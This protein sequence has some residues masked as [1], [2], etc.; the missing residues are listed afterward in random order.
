M[1]K[2]ERIAFRILASLYP[3]RKPSEIRKIIDDALA[4]EECPDD[5]E[6]WMILAKDK[7]EEKPEKE[8][9]KERVIEHHYHDYWHGPYYYNTPTV[10]TDSITITCNENGKITASDDYVGSCC[11][12]NSFEGLSTML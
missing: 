1:T 8:V 12:T 10:T 9:V 7:V 3:D 5:V 4:K 2:Q 11:I 6:L